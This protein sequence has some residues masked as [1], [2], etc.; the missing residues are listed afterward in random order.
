VHSRARA[1]HDRNGFQ[2]RNLLNCSRARPKSAIQ[3]S[4]FHL[5]SWSATESTQTE[6]CD[7]K[8]AATAK[9]L[10]YYV[11]ITN[12]ERLFGSNLWV[13]VGRGNC[14]PIKVYPELNSSPRLCS[15]ARDRN[16]FKGFGREHA[17]A[18]IKS[19]QSSCRMQVCQTQTMQVSCFIQCD[20]QTIYHSSKRCT[21]I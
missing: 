4:I 5:W 17:N 16:I 6:F 8:K 15:R 3:K 2:S 7:R 11:E 14:D 13:K 12:C 1:F 10:D 19:W 9:R 20:I 18:P 21:H